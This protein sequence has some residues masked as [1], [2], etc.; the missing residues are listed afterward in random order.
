MGLIGC[1]L[2]LK[3]FCHTVHL[4]Q[5]NRVS[6]EAIRVVEDA[7]YECLRLKAR[8]EPHGSSESDLLLDMLLLTLGRQLAALLGDATH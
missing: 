4:A 3:P 5:E 2:Y 6:Q 7:I 8:L 1:R